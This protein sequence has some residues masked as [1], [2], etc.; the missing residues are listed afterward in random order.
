MKNNKVVSNYSTY[1]TSFP[2]SMNE[3]HKIQHNRF[4]YYFQSIHPWQWVFEI[5]K[6]EWSASVKNTRCGSRLVCEKFS[7]YFL[8]LRKVFFW[9][10]FL[11]SSII[12][13]NSIVPGFTNL[14]YILLFQNIFIIL[15]SLHHLYPISA[16]FMMS[17]IF[18]ETVFKNALE[19]P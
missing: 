19:R 8:K 2:N 16:N 7:I 4:I 14:C 6:E 9:G 12:Q 13:Y 10:F 11:S 3:C 5:Q 17:I 18:I 1:F 15:Y